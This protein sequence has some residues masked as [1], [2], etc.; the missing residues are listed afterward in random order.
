VVEAALDAS[1]FGWKR[2]E[3]G[4]VVPAGERLPRA[5]EVRP[6]SAGVRVE[7]VLA[8]WD[9]WGA[10]EAAAVGRLLCRAQLGV[11]LVRCEM[12]VRQARVVALLA[13]G[14]VEKALPHTLGGVAAGVRWLTREVG[15]LL[16]PQAA[17]AFLDFLGD[18]G[19]KN[20]PVTA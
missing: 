20:G 4:W 8:T 5:I 15:V 12:D 16:V 18:G 14:Q 6:E 11:R 19:E 17:R 2:R 13:A 10:V 3:E 9:E 1:G 7:A